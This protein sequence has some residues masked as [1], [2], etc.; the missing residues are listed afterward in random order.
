[1]I[2]RYSSLSAESSG[3]ID[4]APSGIVDSGMADYCLIETRVESVLCAVYR[5][6]KIVQTVRVLVVVL[7]TR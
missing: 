7:W 3:C 6:C 2:A 1:M 4:D 5:V